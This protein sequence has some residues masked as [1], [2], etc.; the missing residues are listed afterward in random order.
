[1][2]T[3]SCNIKCTIKFLISKIALVTG[4]FLCGIRESCTESACGF[5]AIS[6]SSAKRSMCYF[7]D[8]GQIQQQEIP[9]LPICLVCSS[10]TR[11]SRPIFPVL[12]CVLLRAAQWAETGKH[13][14]TWLKWFPTCFG[15]IWIACQSWWPGAS[16]RDIYSPLNWTCVS[17]TKLCFKQQWC[18][19]LQQC[20][21]KTTLILVGFLFS[22]GW[23]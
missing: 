12:H 22:A 9:T 7:S 14:Q 2:S 1:M 18:L 13:W 16:R 21:A 6:F 11:G 3:N 4:P 20:S 17:R 19:L 15:N 5:C 23:D 10:S 8:M